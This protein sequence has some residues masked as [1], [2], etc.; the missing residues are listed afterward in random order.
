MIIQNK[1]IEVSN[2]FLMSE[3]WKGQDFVLPDP[4]IQAAQIL[5]DYIGKPLT[6]TSTYR[7]N[8]TFG[9]HRYGEAIDLIP[10]QDMFRLEVIKWID[11]HQSE[12]IYKLR[13]VGITG[14]G[15]EAACIHLD[16]RKDHCH[17]QDQ[18]GW[19]APFEY[20]QDATGKILIN[21]GL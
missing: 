10:G 14:L 1:K 20:K 21:K 12:L 17:R 4:L 9:F 16:V 13:E 19:Y 11:T 8:D 6:I 2:N 3:F 5:R 15:V 7:P 18:F